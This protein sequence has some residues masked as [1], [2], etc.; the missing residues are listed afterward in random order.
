MLIN[1]SS[2]E[3]ICQS[4]AFSKRPKFFLAGCSLQ[5]QRHILICLLYNSL[6]L[7]NGILGSALAGLW[8]EKRELRNFTNVLT[9][10]FGQ[11]GGK[12]K[13]NWAL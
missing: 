7:E 3:Q 1:Y 4:P 10:K 11:S 13:V 5:N 8:G 6:A 9:Q 2:F 12:I